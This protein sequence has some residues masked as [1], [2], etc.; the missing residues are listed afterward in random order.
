MMWNYAIKIQNSMIVSLLL[1][2]LGLTVI[3]IKMMNIRGSQENR[4]KYK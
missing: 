4:Y 3:C 2:L 1:G